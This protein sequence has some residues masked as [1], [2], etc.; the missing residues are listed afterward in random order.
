MPRKLIA[1]MSYSAVPGFPIVTVPAMRRGSCSPNMPA[2]GPSV[3][4]GSARVSRRAW[5]TSVS[6]CNSTRSESY[7]LRTF[8]SMP[9]PMSDAISLGVRTMESGPALVRSVPTFFW[10]DA[11]ADGVGAPTAVS[12]TGGSAVERPNQWAKVLMMGAR[13]HHANA[14]AP[15]TTIAQPSLSAPLRQPSMVFHLIHRT[16][17]GQGTQH[18]VDVLDGHGLVEIGTG[19][20]LF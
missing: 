13:N 18:E 14:S 2:N 19:Q 4:G 12:A 16:L 9:A 10:P 3:P 20:D 11:T 17:R 8:Q 7:V 1:V 15:I 5:S 6:S